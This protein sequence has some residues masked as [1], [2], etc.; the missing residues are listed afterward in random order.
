MFLR[1]SFV[2][3][4]LLVY[5][6]TRSSFL[7]NSWHLLRAFSIWSLASSVT[8]CVHIGGRLLLCKK[9]KNQLI[10]IHS[11]DHTFQ[12]SNEIIVSLK[13]VL[14]CNG[15]KI[16]FNVTVRNNR[17]W[18]YKHTH[19][20]M[21]NKFQSSNEILVSL[22]MVFFLILCTTKSCNAMGSLPFISQHT[23]CNRIYLSWIYT[24]L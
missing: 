1:W 23:V 8:L 20:F 9:Q 2:W 3:S 11:L 14:Q 15:V 18:F 24:P 22:N 12:S 16:M 10:H 6:F 13:M 21:D 17:I 5:T 19:C 7:L 4:M